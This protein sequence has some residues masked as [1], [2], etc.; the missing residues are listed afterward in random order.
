MVSVAREREEDRGRIISPSHGGERGERKEEREEEEGRRGR[1]RE[2]R[3]KK[4][5]MHAKKEGGG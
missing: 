3:K 5:L 2:W 4:R 1:E